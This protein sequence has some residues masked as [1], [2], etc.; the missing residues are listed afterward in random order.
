[1]ERT[2][3]RE[4]VLEQEDQLRTTSEGQP[5]DPKFTVCRNSPP[6]FAKSFGDSDSAS[7]L[8]KLAGLFGQSVNWMRYFEGM[9]L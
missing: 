1:M 6:K 2:G 8:P 9:M 3:Q 5:V 7:H 4:K